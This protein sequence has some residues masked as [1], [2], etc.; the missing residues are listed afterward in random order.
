M[1]MPHLTAQAKHKAAALCQFTRVWVVEDS[2]G[3]RPGGALGHGDNG[4]D[5]PKPLAPGDKLAKHWRLG[6]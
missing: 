6:S 5:S 4:F 1:F 2:R 3:D